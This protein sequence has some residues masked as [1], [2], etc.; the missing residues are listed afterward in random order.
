MLGN[1]Y[2]IMVSPENV[3]N[4]KIMPSRALWISLT[5]SGE[6]PKL[7]CWRGC[8][9][10]IHYYQCMV[11][12]GSPVA[13][14]AWCVL[15]TY[16]SDCGLDGTMFG[17]STISGSGCCWCNAMSTSIVM[18]VGWA[19]LIHGHAVYVMLCDLLTPLFW[20]S[21]HCSFDCNN[22]MFTILH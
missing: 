16:W 20:T 12:G 9:Q 18:Y 22:I 13:G 15:N 7:S 4:I 10:H 1:D 6:R 21:L 19:V 2:C 17:E 11:L 5:A 14:H 3:V 8:H